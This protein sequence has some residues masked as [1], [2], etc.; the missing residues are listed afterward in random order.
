M[1]TN[2]KKFRTKHGL[3]VEGEIS[4]LQ[5]SGD[6]GGQINL[7]KPQTNTTLSSDVAID[8]YQNKIRIFDQGGSNRGAYIDLSAA[9]TG[10]GS[11]LLAGGGS[12]ISNIVE[13]TTPQLGGDLDA[14]GYDITNLNSVTLDTTPTSPGTSPGTIYWDDG[15][16]VPKA[17]LNA[18]VTIGVGQEQILK[19]K[20][21][22]GSTLSK[23]SVVYINGAQG[24]NP[25]VALADADAE[26]TS[27]KTFGFVA[28][29]ILD[30]EEGFVITE[31]IIRGVNTDG[32]TEGNPVWL[33]STAGG[34]TQTMPAEPAHSVFLG[35]AVKAHLTA[36]EIIVKIQNGYE[37]TELHG[38]TIDGTP[39]DNEVLAYDT[40]SGLWIN[41]T[42]SEAGLATSTHDHDSVYAKLTA[43]QT[44]TG[45]QTLT[46]SA[47]GN[48]ALVV[49]ALSGQTGNIAQFQISDGSN[50]LAITKD[51]FPV[52]G[53]TTSIG[54][55][56]SYAFGAT[57]IP[58]AVRGAASQ[59]A[60]L[61]QWQSDTGSVLGRMNAG[62]AFAALRVAA[63]T[64]TANTSSRFFATA[65][66]TT[67]I[68]S[69]I[70]GVA[71][72]S[73]NLT[74]WQD[75]SANVLASVN[76]SGSMYTAGRMIIK[77][78]LS[79]NFQS[80]LSSASMV[81]AIIRGAASQ[82]ANLQEWQDSSANVLAKVDSQ[83]QLTVQGTQTWTTQLAPNNLNF[84]RTS[85]TYVTNTGIGGILNHQV[86][87]STSG[88]TI[89]WSSSANGLYVN[90]SGQL[91]T[92]S[93]PLR[94][95]AT[96]SQTA[97]LQE[98][99]NS[100]GT[101]KLQVN[102]DGDLQIPGNSSII[103]GGGGPNLQFASGLVAT[104][105]AATQ[106]PLTLKGAAS[107]SAN[108]QEWQNSSG[109]MLSR[110][111]PDGSFRGL[112][113]S[114]TASSAFLAQ[115]ENSG[116]VIRLTKQTS[117]AASPSSGQAKIY[118]RDGTNAGTLK[119]ATRAGASGVEETLFDNLDQTGTGSVSLGSSVIVSQSQV[120][121]LTTDL[122]NKANTS[123]V[124]ELARDAIGSALVAG[125]NITI[126]PDDLAD[127]ITIA[128]T[129]T[130]TVTRLQGTGGTLASGDILIQGTG[131]ISTSQSSNTIT[132]A[133][134]AVT[135]VTG[136]SPVSSSGGAT[137]AISL[138]S[139]YG[140]TLNPYGS[141][142]A[143]T[144]L[145][146][147]DGSAGV[148]SF[149]ALTA[150]DIPDLSG[151]KITS[152]SVGIAY[153]GTGVTTGAGITAIIPTSATTGSV[154][155]TGTVTWTGQ[156]SI[157]INGA[158][159]SAYTR[160]RIFVDFTTTNM[161][162]S[163]TTWVLR[164]SG[165][166][167]TTSNY[168][169]NGYRFI[170]WAAAQLNASA[171]ANWLFIDSNSQTGTSYLQGYIDIMYPQQTSRTYMN[172]VSNL[173]GAAGFDGSTYLAGMFNGTTS[174]DGFT[175]TFSAS[176]T[177]TIKIYGYN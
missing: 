73:G 112:Y 170:D 130:N 132:I 18:N 27:S 95:K 137:P 90:S 63:G 76:S 175:I 52:V 154:S 94:V 176:S 108:L 160:Y 92:A 13:D 32:F 75:S 153:G 169:Y 47:I 105:K 44:F 40:T 57:Q 104:A 41:Q 96:A 35:Y 125:S 100:S 123:D 58:L 67:D 1:A 46:P 70:R 124:A 9:A 64:G 118:L 127:T 140:D 133:S 99:Q 38:V 22:T 81:G 116:G 3:E 128:A 114:T 156:T 49:K 21:A 16:G 142:T 146:A 158:F 23:G 106:I 77:T 107:Q 65:V 26:G 50:R 135:S 12:G 62:G 83:G 97:N 110:V 19:V 28:E 139:A 6:E 117:Q 136:T 31:G 126:T 29:A 74:E 2:N 143:N 147:P 165:T 45:L 39:A 88:D 91:P 86:T 131:A 55:I 60:D 68:V 155:A 109:T 151:A 177:G 167:N 72:Q 66:S 8:V 11:N 129:D 148:P 166:N 53:G 78:D 36:G 161:G 51:G 113:F 93:V 34:Y 103:N 25:T 54:N 150:T 42:A 157:S 145:A 102:S 71:S 59:T 89:V 149:R 174:F 10:V 168:S 120:T 173:Y 159:T 162:A 30:T 164:A 33:S 24:Q 82:S 85:N 48:Q 80:V 7:A 56:T 122:G 98:W 121:N 17:I 15:D 144:I 69:I 172:I 87:Q 20:N 141:K 101:V 138:A 163:N 115:E 134:S 14:Q 5:S 111:H 84:S 4:S 152:G 43:D 119:L 171:G 79:A 61:Q 37:L